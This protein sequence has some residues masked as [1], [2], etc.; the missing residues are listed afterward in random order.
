M[1][2]KQQLD[3]TGYATSLEVRFQVEG[4][5]ERDAALIA[6]QV[7]RQIEA[8]LADM[9]AAAAAEHGVTGQTVPVTGVD[10]QGRLVEAYD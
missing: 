8:Q 7:K 2:G 5:T 9:I 6:D 10:R 1:N 3:A 4:V